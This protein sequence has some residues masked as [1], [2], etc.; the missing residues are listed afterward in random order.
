MLL[1][2]LEESKIMNQLFS[3][4]PEITRL[5]VVLQPNGDPCEAEGVL[6]PASTR[7]RQGRL[8]LYSRSVAAG[9]VSR[10]GLICATTFNGIPQFERLG[11]ALEPEADYEFRDSGGYGCEDPRVTFMPTLDQYLMCYTAFGKSGPRIALALS[12]DGYTWRRLGLVRFPAGLHMEPDDKDAA[13]FPLPV[14][15]PTGVQSLAFYHRP[16]T[17]IQCQGNGVIPA[18]LDADPALRACIRI[19][20]VPLEAV[21][22]DRANLTAVAESHLVM[23]PIEQW[24]SLKLGGGSAPVRID[25]G[26][27]SVFHGVDAIKHPDGRYTMRYSA[28]IV[29]HDANEP[30]KV[31]F[32]SATPILA[33]ETPEE[34]I[35]TVNN[36]VFPTA[37]DPRVDLGK[38]VFD[39]YYGMADYKIGLVRLTLREQPINGN[40]DIKT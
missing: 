33:P 36:V 32:R 29:V 38:R 9:N 26:W 2:F 3:L 40:G 20:Y 25:E 12:D 34:L 10:V 22:Q 27:L 23:S 8:L 28:G 11:F 1:L 21:L 6:N 24:G 39:V 30:H 5:G 19:A 31:L 17:G 4:T 7:D 15:S 18:I 37:V 16:A 13:F 35:G 14:M